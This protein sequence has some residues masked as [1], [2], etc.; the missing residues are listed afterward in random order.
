MNFASVLARRDVEA[1]DPIPPPLPARQRLHFLDGLRGVALILMV[2]NHTSRDWLD[3]SMNPGRY[4]LVYGSLLL[5]AAMFL[6]LVGFCLPISYHGRG[7]HA[8]SAIGLVAR[9]A[10][11]GLLVI[12]AGLVLNVLVFPELPV[13]SGGVLQT[14]G[15][16]IVLLAPCLPLMHRP[17]VRRGLLVL[18][19]L[20]YAGFSLLHPTLVAW[21]RGHPLIAQV[22]FLGF[23][24]LPWIAAAMIG[25]VLGWVW[26]DARQR[27]Q[28]QA[29]FFDAVAVVGFVCV[30]LYFTWEWWR[31]SAAK[32]GFARDFSL[33]GHWTPR[34]A[35]MFLVAGGVA[36]SLAGTY[37]FMHV[38][39]YRPGWLVVLGQ[40]ALM[41]Y[42]VHQVIE[43][44]L[45]SRALGW[46]FTSWWAYWAANVAFVAV[47][48][49]LARVWPETKGAL[50][51][52]V[53]SRRLVPARLNRP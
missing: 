53:A 17:W 22:A 18:A 27:E 24:P 6:F 31:P 36:A 13:W 26:L 28:G 14:I 4:Y 46:R 10:R 23:P 7:A 49:V 47:L 16:G 41:L 51:R 35:T 40:N 33:N 37:R 38:R 1:P 8:G 52:L 20:V 50:R 9:Y 39:G 19:V 15:L 29:R 48:V 5:P 12:A 42:F 43:M 44:T 30:V 34:G 25:L 2:V 45:V 32:F 21:S 3:A 11:R